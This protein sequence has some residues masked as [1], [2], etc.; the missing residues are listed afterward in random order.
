MHRLTIALFL[1]CSPHTPAPE[2]PPPTTAKPVAT[3]TAA[4]PREDASLTPR[5]VFFSNPDRARVLI[6][7]DGKNISFLANDAAGVLNVF[8]APAGDP[9]NAKQLTQEKK[10]NL[11]QYVWAFDN[12]HILYQQDIGG[13]E[14]WRVYSADISSGKNEEIVAIDG[15][16]A[17][18]E[19]VSHKRPNDVVVAMNDRDKKN[20]DLYL[21]DLKTNKRTLL[22]KNEAGYAG[23]VLDDDLAV[24]DRKST[25]L[26]SSHRL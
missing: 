5:K 12:K 9:S 4:V 16:Q 11:R 18:I 3:Q 2:V 25:R 1:A 6:S 13:D 26:N 10:R 22:E 21:V 14:N 19:S 17:R 15:V 8:V 7:P 23:Y 24:R 20:H